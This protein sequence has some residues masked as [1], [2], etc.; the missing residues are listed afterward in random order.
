MRELLGLLYK[1]SWLIAITLPL[2]SSI[3]SRHVFIVVSDFGAPQKNHLNPCT[4]GSIFSIPP[5]QRSSSPLP[6]TE[7]DQMPEVYPGRGVLKFRFDRRITPHF[8]TGDM[9]ERGSETLN[10]QLQN[11]A[12]WTSPIFQNELLQILLTSQ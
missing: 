10:T 9:T 12:Q 7:S 11:H 2:N 3:S 1:V 5:R 8:Q 6:G 4:S